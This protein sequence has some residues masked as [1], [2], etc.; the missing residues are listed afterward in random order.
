MKWPLTVIE[1]IVS[2][3][4]IV[5]LSIICYDWGSKYFKPKSNIVVWEYRC[6]DTIS[7][8]YEAIEPFSE[9]TI[10]SYCEKL[11]AREAR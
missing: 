2:T 6:T 9:E 7:F 8:S 4:I 5:I 10:K 3:I 11:I 1:T